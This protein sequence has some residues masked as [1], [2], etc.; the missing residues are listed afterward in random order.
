MSMGNVVS[1]F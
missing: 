1:G